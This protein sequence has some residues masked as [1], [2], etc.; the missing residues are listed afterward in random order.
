MRNLLGRLP[1]IVVAPRLGAVDQ[2]VD[3]GSG[4]KELRQ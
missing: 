2:S 4:M 3:D 1:R